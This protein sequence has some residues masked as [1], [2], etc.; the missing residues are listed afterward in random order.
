MVLNYKQFTHIP[1]KTFEDS[2]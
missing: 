2:Y 1:Y